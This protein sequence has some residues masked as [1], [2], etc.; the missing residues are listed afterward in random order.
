[1]DSTHIVI[2]IPGLGDDTRKLEFATKH[3]INHGLIPYVYPVGWHKEPYDFQTKLT[4]LLCLIDN[5]KSNGSKVSLIGC[6]AGGSAVLNA[7]C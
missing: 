2:I 5:Y 4:Q 6:S 3:F 7:F 1:M